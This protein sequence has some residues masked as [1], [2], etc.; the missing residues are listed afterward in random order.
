MPVQAPFGMSTYPDGM[1][2]SLD[3]VRAFIAVAEERHFGR[4]AE[5]LA[6][7]Q[8]PLSRSIQKLERA[9]GATL[10]DRDSR[11][12][13]VTGAGEA[14]L[15][16]CHRMVAL[17]DSAS[18][19]ARRV[20]RGV[21][22][23]LR[24]GFTAVSAI[25]LLGPLLARIEEELPDVRVELREGVTSAQ[26]EGLRRG[27]LDLGLARP[28]FDTGRLASRLLVREPL[29]AVLP[30][31][32]RLAQHEGPLEPGDFDGESVIAYDPVRARYFQ[33]LSASFLLNAH[34]RL[35]QQVHQVLTAILLVAAGRGLALAPASAI[36]L[37]VAG[38]VH[39]ELRFAAGPAARPVELHAIWP[40]GAA[41]PLLRR[42]LDLLAALADDPG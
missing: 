37:G 39:K 20:D 6:M 34:P 29:H 13:R 19:A 14:F 17:V 10:L 22:G 33:E 36:H 25:G 15:L 41:S 12:V 8:P 38:V 4:A 26:V 40:R 16:D 28:P 42:A 2:Y 23:V 35:E 7:T 24:L 11:G 31:G 3:Q 9:V 21:A 32:H 18:D 27:E 30:V 5:R 1:D